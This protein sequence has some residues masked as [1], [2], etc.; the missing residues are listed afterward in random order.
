MV[1]SPAMSSNAIQLLKQI[2][3][4]HCWERFS[5]DRVL[6]IAQHQDL[7]GDPRLGADE[8]QRFLPTRFNIGGDALDAKGF[9]CHALACPKC[10]LSLPRPLLELEPLFLSIFGAPSSGKSYFLAA[11]TWELRRVLP[12]KFAMSFADA[13]PT[14][15]V[16]LNDY[17]ESLFV[18]AA[19]DSVVPLGDL[20]RK[21]EEQGEWYNEVSHGS[22]TV[23]YSRPFLFTM[24]PESG[25]PNAAKS[26]K[27]SRTVCLYD[28]AGEQ[29]QAG[30]DTAASP[31]TRHMAQSRALFFLFD[32]TQDSRF[33]KL[34]ASRDLGD[35]CPDTARATRQEPYL[36]EAA[37]RIRRYAH[38]RQ[39]EKH[40]RPLIVILTKYD[41]WGPL[42]N[43]DPPAEPWKKISGGKMGDVKSEATIHA[44]DVGAVKRQSQLARRMLLEVSPE[45]VTAAEGF[46]ENVTY[47][48]VSAVGPAAHMGAFDSDGNPQLAIRPS[49]TKP[50][51]V[52][53]P[54]LYAVSQG[55]PGMIPFFERAEKGT[56]RKK[57]DK[58]SGAGG[59]VVNINDLDMFDSLP[60][61]T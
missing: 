13:D 32:P 28:N 9:A 16:I 3:C 20:I 55:L 48:P 26:V 45:I 43:E 33:R 57:S 53:V 37:T 6:W 46:A 15:N 14:L 44:I 7:R 11:M 12:L 25:H 42:L 22:Q 58:V 40:Q 5:P 31:V 30:K 60:K 2:T 29:F 52:T 41:S 21:T 27:C 18:N 23:K 61:E 56:K 8:H 54:F 49:E 10:H 59:T 1:A 35:I 51:W 17:E 36:Q 47:V 19:A 50:H 4:P 24:Q 39:S 34:C 38:L